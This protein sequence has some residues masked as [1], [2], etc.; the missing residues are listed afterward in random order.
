MRAGERVRNILGAVIVLLSMNSALIT[1]NQHK[2]NKEYSKLCDISQSLAVQVDKLKAENRELLEDVQELEKVLLDRE[3]YINSLITF[4]KSSNQ[5]LSDS[6]VTELA[7]LVDSVTSEFEEKYGFKKDVSLLLAIM[8]AESCFY[9]LSPNEAEATGYVQ[10]TP[11]CLTET[12]SKTGW[13]YSME[14]MLEARKNLE[15]GWYHL[16]SDIEKFGLHKA[17]VAYN[18]GYNNLDKAVEVS[19]Q[20][21]RSYLSTVLNYAQKVESYLEGGK[22][23]C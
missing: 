10:I 12:N 20:D 2:L 5:N 23:K 9:N 8:R 17:I 14:E 1:Y 15:V 13:G 3:D 6:K 4:I 19:L 22:R 7:F 21:E 16:N 11:V 18:Q